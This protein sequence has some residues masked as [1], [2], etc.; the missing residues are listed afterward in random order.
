MHDLKKAMQELSQFYGQGAQAL[1]R[2]AT[3]VECWSGPSRMS[4]SRPL[5]DTGNLTSIAMPVA[6]P[7]AVTPAVLQAAVLPDNKQTSC[8]EGIKPTTH[9]FRQTMGLYEPPG[10]RDRRPKESFKPIH[11][12]WHTDSFDPIDPPEGEGLFDNL[13]TKVVEEGDRQSDPYNNFG[14]F[15]T[16]RK[17]QTSQ[18]NKT[19]NKGVHASEIPV[20]DLSNSTMGKSNEPQMLRYPPVITHNIFTGRLSPA[21]RGP[22]SL[23]TPPTISRRKNDPIQRT[24]KPP[25]QFI[26]P[27]FNTPAPAPAT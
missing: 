25:S 1:N 6:R 7:P 17:N 8:W 18:T 21:P 15:V 26:I 13:V 14:D 5:P 12:V 3:A 19:P 2:I 23:P 11:N 22:R 27:M 9:P 16:L 10:A 20:I 4:K 24:G